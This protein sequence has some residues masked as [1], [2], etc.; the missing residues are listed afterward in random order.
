MLSIDIWVRSRVARV[1]FLSFG[2]GS[3]EFDG[4]ASHMHVDFEGRQVTE[5]GYID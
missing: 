3:G 5:F 4:A 2:L 1:V